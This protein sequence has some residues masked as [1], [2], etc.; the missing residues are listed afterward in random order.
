MQVKQFPAEYL[1][2]GLMFC[3]V[4]YVPNATTDFAERMCQRGIRR[5]TARGQSLPT[6]L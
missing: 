4:P 1:R 5:C 6:N 3:R 2:R